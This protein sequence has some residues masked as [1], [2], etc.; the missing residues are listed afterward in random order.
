MLFKRKGENT[1]KQKAV[2]EAVFKE[3]RRLPLWYDERNLRITAA[4]SAF[5]LLIV[6]GTIIFF[7]PKLPPEIPL[8]FNKIGSEALAP[9]INLYFLPLGFA[10]F[11]LLNFHLAH[12]FYRK[13]KLL[14]QLLLYLCP[15]FNLM[16]ILIILKLTY[17]VGL[18]W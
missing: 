14:S 15:F 9:K 6:W 13:E 16:L 8:F 12:L 3:N 17:L 7:Y 1:V 2:K 10:F 4:F 18:I 5:F 11:T